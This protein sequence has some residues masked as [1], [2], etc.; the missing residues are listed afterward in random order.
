[1]K[2]KFTPATWCAILGIT[3]IDPDG[4]D[5][6]GNFQRDW[7]EPLSFDDFMDKVNESTCLPMPDRETLRLMAVNRIC[8]NVP[9]AIQEI[10]AMVG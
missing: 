4:W 9:I 6:K 1:M 3:I 7:S 5:R 8:P 10:V 2:I